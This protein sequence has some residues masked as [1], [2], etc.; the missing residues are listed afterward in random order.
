MS[1]ISKPY[2]GNAIR[3]MTLLFGERNSAAFNWLI[4]NDFRELVECAACIKSGRD[5]SFRWLIDHKHL[6][7]AAFANAVR[8]DKNAF[9]WLM[10]YNSV[11]WAATANAVNKDK[12][13]MEWLRVKGFDVYADLANAIIDYFSNESGDVSGYYS[14]PI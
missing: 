2:H 11:F 14:A 5:A 6:E 13:A 12:K 1:D 10:Q 9:R 7:V 8:G 3:Q 4:E